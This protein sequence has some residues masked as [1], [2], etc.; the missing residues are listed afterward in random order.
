[1]DPD[2]QD[3]LVKRAI[4]FEKAHKSRTYLVAAPEPSVPGKMEI[5]AH[6][7][8]A[9]DHHLIRSDVSKTLKRK[10]SG[11]FNN[12]IVPCYLL[13]QMGRNDTCSKE[14]LS[15][16]DLLAHALKILFQAHGLVGGRFVRIDC[17]E[18]DGLLR[19]YKDNGFTLLPGRTTNG[20]CQFVKFISYDMKQ[21]VIMI[22]E[23]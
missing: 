21:G 12:D 1:M 20:L 10:L 14:L 23:P 13:G 19:F 22:E 17:K 18:S 7:S 6:F 5:L 15:G 11:I 16:V 9:I 3:F 8:V 4:P 2:I